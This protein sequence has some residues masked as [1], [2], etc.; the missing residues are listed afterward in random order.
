[1]ESELYECM[2][3]KDLKFDSVLCYQLTD[4][5]SN[6]EEV[7]DQNGVTILEDPVGLQPNF[8]GIADVLVVLNDLLGPLRLSQ[9]K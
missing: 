9:P 1:M 4:P 2:A 6:A 8:F 3:P 5:G 7:P